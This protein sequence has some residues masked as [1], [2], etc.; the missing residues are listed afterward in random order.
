MWSESAM[1]TRVVQD[2]GGIQISQFESR[3][4]YLSRQAEP[5]PKFEK[6]QNGAI[7]CLL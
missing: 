2:G 7:F 4:E 1:T 3:I 5:D 6:N